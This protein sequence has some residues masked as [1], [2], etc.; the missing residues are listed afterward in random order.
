MARDGKPTRA[1]ILAESKTLVF[2]NGFSG[3]SIDQ[4]L[5]R[6]GITKGAFFYHFK[7]KNALAQALIEEFARDDIGHM[8][9][10]LQ[11][12][13]E[14]HSDPLDRL[15]QFIQEFVDLMSDLEDPPSCL[16][17]SYTYEPSQFEPEI[18]EFIS[19]TLLTWRKTF[20]QLLENVLKEYN[21]KVEVDIAALSNLF[22]VIFEGSYV[23]SKALNDPALISGQLK[24]LKN[25]FHLLFEKK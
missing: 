19:E 23:V 25:Y 22:T 17:A 9:E 13:G 12:T 3:T 18:L 8:Q 5:A 24:E 11:K 4:I 14:L 15:L 2:E 20:E 6:T 7:T 21:T 10:A 16:Y 1:K